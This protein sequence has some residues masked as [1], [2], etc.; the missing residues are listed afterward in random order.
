MKGENIKIKTDDPEIPEFTYHKYQFKDI[1]AL[2]K[3][4]DKKI[5]LTKTKKEKKD[6]A[7]DKLKKDLDKEI[8]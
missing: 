7:F 3:E 1:E 4:M 5:A 8:A 2:K 6:L